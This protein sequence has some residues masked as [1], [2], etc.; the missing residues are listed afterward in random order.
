MNSAKRSMASER[1]AVCAR[2]L[3]SKAVEAA[4]WH[5]NG[6]MATPSVQLSGAKEAVQS[7]LPMHGYG[8]S[9]ADRANVL[10]HLDR[11]GKER[12]ERARTS[13]NRSKEWCGPA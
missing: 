8:Y 4:M 1:I 7:G 6:A 5:T 10:H 11:S 9:V 12:S 3:D 13:R 2:T